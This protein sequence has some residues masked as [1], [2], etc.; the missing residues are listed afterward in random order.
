MKNLG[1]HVI[2]EHTV[3][4]KIYC[5]KYFSTH[6]WSFILRKNILNN[7]TDFLNRSTLS[8]C[9]SIVQIKNI[10][11]QTNA[12]YF[13]MTNHYKDR[14]HWRNCLYSKWNIL[15]NCLL[16][17]MQKKNTFYKKCCCCWNYKQTNWKENSSDRKN[18]ATN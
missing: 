3:N 4:K 13:K 6:S 17:S 15:Y 7:G 2:F 12:T 16:F 9:K 18:K 11:E 14:G 10:Y 1:V 5:N 8:P